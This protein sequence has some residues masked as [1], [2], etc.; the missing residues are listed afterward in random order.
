MH[1]KIHVGLRALARRSPL[2]RALVSSLLFG[3]FAWTFLSRCDPG[4]AALTCAAHRRVLLPIDIP[5]RSCTK[6]TAFIHGNLNAM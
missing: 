1:S 4:C 2:S 5:Q 6:K 3:M